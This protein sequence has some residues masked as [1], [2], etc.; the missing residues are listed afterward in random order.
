MPLSDH[1]QQLLAQ[2]ERALYADDPKLASTLRGARGSGH[3][4]RR[5]VVGAVGLVAGVGLLI[6]GVSSQAW[7]L[8]VVGFLVML[9]AAW[10]AS[11]G[12]QTKGVAQAEPTAAPTAQPGAAPSRPAKAPRSGFMRRIEQRWDR[13]R[14]GRDR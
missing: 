8:G 11:S 14:D 7:P 12:W 3:D 10:V 6:G 4:R 2:M 9:G 13:R 5:I 1:E